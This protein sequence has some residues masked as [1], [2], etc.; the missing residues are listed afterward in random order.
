MSKSDTSLNTLVYITP[1]KSRRF[2]SPEGLGVKERTNNSKNAN[3][4][5]VEK[6][7]RIGFSDFLYLSKC[8]F[9]NLHAFYGKKCKD[10]FCRIFLA[11][12]FLS[13]SGMMREE[14]GKVKIKSWLRLFY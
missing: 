12:V 1:R 14:E 11:N 2:L 6:T 13:V 3:A 10:I 7:S 5:P 4:F 8:T 9:G